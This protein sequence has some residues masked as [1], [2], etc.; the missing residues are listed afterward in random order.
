M[1]PDSIDFNNTK[2]YKV[3]EKLYETQKLLELPSLSSTINFNLSKANEAPIKRS[4]RY[5][6]YHQKGKKY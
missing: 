2:N 3:F 5:D 6:A 1:N 4:Q